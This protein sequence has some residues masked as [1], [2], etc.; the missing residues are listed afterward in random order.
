MPI[1]NR[2][3]RRDTAKDG[4]A[5]FAEMPGHL[6]RR[7]QQIAVAIFM[8]ECSE[9]ELTPIQYAALAAIR[10]HPGIDA[11]RL[12]GLIALDKPTTGGVVD[13]LEAK[14]LLARSTDAEDRRVK[15]LILTHSGERL[16]KRAET[17]VIATQRRILEPLTD[18][19]SRMFLQLLARL[20]AGNNSE[21][22]APMRPL[23]VQGQTP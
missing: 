12:A 2:N 18:A 23:N 7:A 13:R 15:R 14:G 3:I 4:A 21:S 5:A 11:T 1:V 10:S 19:E 6:I 20:V 8:D 22:R 9:L 16:L 17:A